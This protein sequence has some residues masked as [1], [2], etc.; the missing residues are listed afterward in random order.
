MATSIDCTA[1][2][3]ELTDL[4]SSCLS[5][6]LWKTTFFATLCFVVNYI[7]RL[8]NTMLRKEQFY[9]KNVKKTNQNTVVQSVTQEHVHLP[10]INYHKAKTSCNGIR[11]KTAYVPLNKFTDLQLLSDYRTLEEIDRSVDNARRRKLPERP[12]LPKYLKRMKS[13]AKLRKINLKFLPFC[14]ERHSKNKTRFL[15]REE[16]FLWQIEWIFPIANNL[17]V[18]QNRLDENDQVNSLYENLLNSQEIAD[19]KLKQCQSLSSSNIKIFM[20]SEFSSKIKYE[21]ID[22][23]K[24]LKENLQNKTV[25]EYPAFIVVPENH[26]EMYMEKSAFAVKFGSR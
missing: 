7:N 24:T 14:F 23:N 19:T 18:I 9:V 15:Y 3:N 10:C 20:K 13:A 6:G 8:Y 1:A 25:V 21:E 11:D 26:S 12:K 5:Y 17:S 16:K 4:N 2:E 22:V